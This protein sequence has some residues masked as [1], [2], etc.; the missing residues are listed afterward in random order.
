MKIQISLSMPEPE[1]P[2]K[3]FPPSIEEQVRHCLELIESGYRSDR[4]WLT[5]SKLYKS[6]QGKKKTPRVQNLINMIEP[7][8]AHFGYHKVSAE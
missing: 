6:L 8:L 5:I 7:V 4:E 1:A 2:K 3:P